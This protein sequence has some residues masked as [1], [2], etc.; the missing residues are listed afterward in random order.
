MMTAIALKTL[1]HEFVE[2]AGPY[3][4]INEK[5]RYIEAIE[6]VEVLLEEADDSENDPLNK[7][8]DVLTQSIREYENRDQHIAALDQRVSTE[9]A[10]RAVLRVLMDQHHLTMSDFPE[11]GSK[12][13]VSRVLSGQRNLTKKHI[14]AL[15]QRFHISPVLFFNPMR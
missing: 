8:I 2:A 5:K 4:K 1:C 13:M 15:C 11:I 10:E 7:I 6:L 14:E 12:S 3:L 9:T